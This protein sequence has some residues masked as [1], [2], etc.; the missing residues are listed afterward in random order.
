MKQEV[1]KLERERDIY[2]DALRRIYD[3]AS[4]VDDVWLNIEQ[5]AAI[6]HNALN[7]H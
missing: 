7:K 1:T 3:T 5:I 4:E 6:S 2:E